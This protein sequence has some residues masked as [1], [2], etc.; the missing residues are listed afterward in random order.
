[1]ADEV[2]SSKKTILIVDNSPLARMQLGG[3]LAPTYNIVEAEEGVRALE[4]MRLYGAD[5]LAA[6]LLDLYM[7]GMTGYDVLAEKSADP[8]IADI[9]VVVVTADALTTAEVKALDAGAADFLIKPIEPE[10]VRRRIHSVVSAREI[11]EQRMRIRI[12]EEAAWRADHDDLTGIYSRKAF[13]RNTQVMLANDLDNDYLLALWDIEKFKLV[14]ELFGTTMG[15]HALQIAARS[16]A[17]HIEGHGT[18]G[19]LGND[20]FVFCTTRD[21]VDIPKLMDE[22]VSE[23]MD[24]FGAME[25]SVTL[26]IATGVYPVENHDMDVAVMLD[27]ATMAQ[28]TIKG[29]YNNHIAYYDTEL[30]NR[31]YEEQD[32]LNNMENA[33]E[34]GEFRVQLQPVYDL[35]T[36]LPTSAEAL[37]RWHRPGYGMVP[38]D[39]FVPLFEKNGFISKMDRNIWEQVC[40]T[41]SDRRDKNL[42]EIPILV[43]LSRRSAY[44][45]DLFDTIVGLTEKYAIKPELLR[46]EVT[47]SSYID[48]PNRLIETVRRLQ[49]HGFTILMD[50]FGSGYSSL[51]AL[52][53]IPVDILKIDMQFMRGFEEGGRVGTILTSVIR[54]ARWLGIPVIA[55]GVETVEQY[56]F[57]RSI[58]CEY[59]QGFYFACPMDRDEFEQQLVARPVYLPDKEKSFSKSDVDGILGGDHLLDRMMNGVLDGYAIFEWTSEKLE[60]IRSN[61]GFLNIFGYN[62]DSYRKE[63]MHVIDHIMLDDRHRFLMSCQQAAE[64]HSQTSL[65]IQCKDASD[66]W[67]KLATTL[68]CVSNTAK[69]ALLFVAFRYADIG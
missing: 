49:D 10:I 57:L 54:M 7:P 52:K 16:L 61:E 25:T 22:I 3:I 44:S 66:N 41:L 11:E 47:E 27:R 15:D 30:S 68:I 1:M 48:D 29:N 40:Q 26:V 13:L 56:E 20:D 51:N 59:T 35:S 67:T 69:S 60:L 45:S 28:R 65:T 62:V 2:T 43:N 33:L 31:L 32:I 17:R 37:V 34:N 42:P 36:G 46:I 50:D 24:T 5:D 58:G 55:E 9:P 14:N 8:A 19:R 6:V 12:L 21:S 38:P 4:L 23:T 64:A 53:D 18:Y 63:S 39:H